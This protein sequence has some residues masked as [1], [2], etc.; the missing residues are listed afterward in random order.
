MD[1]RSSHNFVYFLAGFTIMATL[2]MLTLIMGRPMF[3]EDP[4][5]TVR[6]LAVYAPLITGIGFG[7]RVRHFGKRRGLRLVSAVKAA[8]GLGGRPP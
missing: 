8:F 4:S 6:Y 7:L 5:M 1:W 2:T 3:G